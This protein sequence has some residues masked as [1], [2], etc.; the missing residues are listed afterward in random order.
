MFYFASEFNGALTHSIL[1]SCLGLLKIANLTTEVGGAWD[2]F[3]TEILII[4]S[5]LEDADCSRPAG[6][7]L[8]GTSV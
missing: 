2:A 4:Y 7:A 5:L 8:Q 3:L 1:K 6:W